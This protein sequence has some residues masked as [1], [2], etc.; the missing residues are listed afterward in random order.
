MNLIVDQGNSRIKLAVF[1]RDTLVET[2]IFSQFKDTE[3]HQ[4]S[5]KYGSP[6]NCIVSNVSANEPVS[7]YMQN[8]C[9]KVIDLDYTTP[10]P[11]KLNYDTPQTLGKDRLAGMVGA[12]NLFPGSHVMVIDAGTAITFDLL[13]KNGTFFGGTISPGLE[14][15]FKALNMF[16]GKLPLISVS[17]KSVFPNFGKSTHEAISSGVVN[18]I[19][20]EIEGYITSTNVSYPQL[21]IILTGGDAIFFEK[22]L[23]NSIFVDLNLLSIGLNTI[24]KYNV[25]I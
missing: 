19:L 20:N 23:K 22:K 24:L 13:T 11:I 3:F 4:I 2:F 16:T 14:M 8:V 10:L 9:N 6:T 25:A 7:T 18:G 21:K 17:G 12:Y 5:L 1:D 15:R